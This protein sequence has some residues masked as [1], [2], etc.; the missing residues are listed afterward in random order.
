MWIPPIGM[1]RRSLMPRTARHS[2]L[3]VIPFIALSFLLSSCVWSDAPDGSSEV[4]QEAEGVVQDTEDF[5]TL[6]VGTR[7]AS[8]NAKDLATLL[9]STGVVFV[10][11]VVGLKG[12]RFE[13]LIPPHRSSS[14]NPEAEARPTDVDGPQPFPISLFDVRVERSLVGGLREGST[15][16]VQ[17]AGGITERSDGTTIRLVLEFDEPLE[18]NTTYLF[19]VSGAPND[20]GTLVTSPFARLRLEANGRFLPLPE[21]SHLN[22]LRQL[23]GLDIE[24]AERVVTSVAAQ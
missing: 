22:G 10:G 1:G 9:R 15:V 23:T 16:T 21:W 4:R 14:L 7:W 18:A 6:Y 13:N 24:Q 19:W 11:N 2:V 5:P 8:N 17:Q 20:S 12:Q 3:F